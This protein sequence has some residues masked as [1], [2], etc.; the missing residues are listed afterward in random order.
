MEKEDIEKKTLYTFVIPLILITIL[1]LII[2]SNTFSFSFH[3]DDTNNI[4]ENKR[5]Q[6]L[7]NFLDFSG[8]RYIGDISFG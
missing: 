4:I 5:I 7:S 2:Y 8:T 6:T 1:T 3:L